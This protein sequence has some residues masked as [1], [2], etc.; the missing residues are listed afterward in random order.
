MAAPTP[1]RDSTSGWLPLQP[2]LDPD[3]CSS[4]ITAPSRAGSTRTSAAA[5]I[6]TATAGSGLTPPPGTS[7]GGFTIDW[8]GTVVG[9]GEATL[10][11]SDQPTRHTSSA[12]V[13]HSGPHDVYAERLRHH[14]ARGDRG[15]LVRADG[16]CP[17]DPG[18]LHDLA[19]GDDAQRLPRSAGDERFGDLVS[20]PDAAGSARASPSR[21]RTP[22][23][24]SIGSSCRRTARTSLPRWCPMPR[25]RCV[26]VD[27]GDGHSFA[28]PQPCPLEV[29]MTMTFDSSTAR[30]RQHSIG[31]LRWRTRPGTGRCWSRPRCGPWCTAGPS[32]AVTGRC[33]S[34]SG[35][36][37]SRRPSRV[38]SR[39]CSGTLTL[40]GAPVP[41]ALLDVLSKNRTPGVD[42]A[43]RSREVRHGPAAATTRS[44]CRPARRGCCGSPT[45][46][47]WPTTPTPPTPISIQ[48]VKA[49][50]DLRA[51]TKHVALARD[52]ALQRARCAAASSRIAAS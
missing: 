36:T 4:T 10:S 22:V 19:G 25:G 39:R 50:V 46:R 27:P 49:R 41:G 47:T 1:I 32:T 12:T 6:R 52:R 17:P 48:R 29:H 8:S 23:A 40:N 15:M 20:D 37:R 9:G 43:Q 24:G 7:L 28:W 30:R 34:G 11:R 18:R 38:A 35:A 31:R 14:R 3:S 51:L 26:N 13:A 33:S 42:A 5:V 2:R 45:R 44:G 16:S 21:P